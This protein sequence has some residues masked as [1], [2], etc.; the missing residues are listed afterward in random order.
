MSEVLVR[1][2]D[3]GK[4][5]C[6][7]LKRSLWY[8]LKDSAADIFG[9]KRSRNGG[10]LHQEPP[11]LRPGEFWSNKD[12]S[13]ELK[14][15]ECLGLI[16]RNG[17]GKTT[18]LKMLNGLIKPDAGRIEVHGK[19]G[20]LIALG[21]GFSSV[22]TGRENIYVNGSILGLSRKQI[23]DRLEQIVDFAELSDSIDSPV[24]NYSSG[25]QV[26]L[27]FSAAVNL[28]QPDI[29][30]LDE[31]LAVGDIGFT[32][33]CLNAMRKLTDRCAVIFV[34]HSMQFVSTFCTHAMMLSKGC[35]EEYSNDLGLIIDHY[36]RCFSLVE[37]RSGSGEAVIHSILMK[38]PGSDGPS[39]AHIAVPH[40]REIE[41]ELDL[42]T[43]RTAKLHVY[44]MS[45]S[46][47]PVICSQVVGS[48]GHFVVIAPGRQTVKL[49]LGQI[50]FNAGLYPLVIAMSDVETKQA[51]VRLEATASIRVQ[52]DEVDWGIISRTF[53]VVASEAAERPTVKV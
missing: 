24:R 43:S 38:I 30:L 26:R 17:A 52:K 46:L 48:D 2:E 37:G 29:L 8:G 44:I 21:A 19:V 1:C 9:A 13:F 45:Q 53:H 6:R 18:L 39:V 33:K 10:D 4:K 50:D 32:I 36:H 3:V 27:G 25:M 12:V 41:M 7:E 34:T 35:I 15:G 40:G 5:F 51:L 14:R 22:L 42:E 31:V 47:A 28:I 49:S 23:D 20:G 11:T 16:G